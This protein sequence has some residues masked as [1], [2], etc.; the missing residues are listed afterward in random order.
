[1]SVEAVVNR[2]F[3]LRTLELL[4][5]PFCFVDL[6]LYCTKFSYSVFLMTKENLEYDHDP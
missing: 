1:M 2:L 5:Y 6:R 3:F 4:E